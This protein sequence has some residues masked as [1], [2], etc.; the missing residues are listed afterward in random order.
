[1]GVLEA[2]KRWLNRADAYVQLT[3]FPGMFG[4]KR[5]SEASRAM[6]NQPNAADKLEEEPRES[7]PDAELG[8]NT[9]DEAVAKRK[10]AIEH[11]RSLRK[12]R[13]A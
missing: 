7:L 3:S 10:A 5:T 2:F 12:T 6:F 4:R 13:R 11:E 8:G 9:S 1:M